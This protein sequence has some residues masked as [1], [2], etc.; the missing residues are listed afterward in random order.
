MKPKRTAD[1]SLFLTV[2][3]LLL[4]SLAFVYTASASFSAVKMGASESMLFN[5]AKKVFL[6]LVAMIVFT[7]IDY[8]KFEKQTKW[9]MIS[10]LVLLVA[11]LFVGTRELGA[12]RWLALGP[13]SFQPAEFAKFALVLHVAALCAAKQEIIGDFKKAFLPIAFWAVAAAALI[14][15]QPNMSTASVLI[16][17]A[18]GIMYVAQV[19]L[20]Y[21]LT[22]GALALFG[23]GI[24]AL[25]ASYR[26]QRMLAFV[27]HHTAHTSQVAYQTDQALIAFGNGGIFG[28]GIGQSRQSMFFL[29]E[30]YGDFIYSVIGEEYGFIGAALLMIVFG[31]LVIR[32]IQIAKHAPDAF[33][34]YTA[35][36]ITITLAIYVM[37]NAFVNVGL[38]PVTGLPMPFVSYG[39]TSMIFSAA[40][41]G[42]LLNISKYA[43]TL[44]KPR[45]V[46]F[47]ERLSRIV[48]PPAEEAIA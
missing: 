15:K 28:V 45:R 47:S 48:K 20:K 36:G 2:T 3:G 11:V 5:H 35:F 23:G 7:K 39:G 30:S 21:M 25:T 29:P 32:G 43:V 19:P 26:V 46:T 9:I 22:S 41:V 12:R 16:L 42:I 14:A 37:I 33:G 4:A 1:L 10:S 13:L 44:P 8:H 18:F 24:F 34:R 27:G 38:L 17:I 31:F 6:S 40:A